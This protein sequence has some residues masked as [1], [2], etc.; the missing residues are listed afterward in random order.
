MAIVNATPDSFYKNSQYN[1]N[2]S[3][4]AYLDLCKSLN[5]SFLDVGAQSTRPGHEKV[6]SKAQIERLKPIL[7]FIKET[8]PEIH[9]S[10]DTSCPE[11]A[12]WALING[13]E[14]IND[15]EGG[16]NSPEIWSVC[17]S[18]QAPYILMHSKGASSA[19]HDSYDYENVTVDVL[20]ELS[21]S[22]NTIKSKGVKDIIIDPGFGFS[23]S[24]EENHVL[25]SNLK[26]FQ[27]FEHPLLVGISR[28]S[29][30]YKRLGVDSDA[31]INGTTILNTYALL[32]GASF[33][34]VH[35]PREA[36]EII[37]LFNQE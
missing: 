8:L 23:K 31:A 36:Y 37:Q 3:L 34:R 27:L 22:L 15:I 12:D 1:D 6:D 9:I 35:D 30:I 26:L 10:I 16:K 28:K 20:H 24:I 17:A 2:Q 7:N 11:V 32:N 29:M 4:K 25:M 14:I 21:A 33:L 5:I 13:G 18:H 19:L